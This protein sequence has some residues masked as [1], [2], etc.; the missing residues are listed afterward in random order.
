[1]T[2]K[3]SFVFLIL[4]KS[5]LES[6]DSLCYFISFSL[7]FPFSFCYNLFLS[8][9]PSLCTC[10]HS[11]PTVSC[12][13]YNLSRVPFP[14][15]IQARRVFLQNNHISEIG[16]GLFSPLTSVLWLFSNHITFL[17]PD[18]FHRLE[19]LEE[20]DLSNNPYLPP[21]QTNTFEGL[22][23]L[24]SLHLY[25]CHI[26]WLPA[27]LFKGLYSLRYLY[28]QHNH[29]TQLQDG[30]F[31]DLSNLSQLFLHGNLLQSLSTE[32][33]LGL[34]N[35]DRLLL[36][37]NQLV[38]V[39]TRAFWG[40]NSLTVLFLFNNSLSSLPGDSLQPLT[41]LQFLRLNGNPW[42]C[43][44][45]CHSLWGWFH[46]NP[47]IS[48]SPVLCA[49]P[50]SLQGRDMRSLDEKDMHFCSSHNPSFTRNLSGIAF[51]PKSS[52]FNRGN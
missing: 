5:L 43:D 37:S 12:Q 28:L 26:K 18:T 30:L 51:S 8:P 9:C 40:L 7:L 50:P 3:I 15:P 14:L 13:S 17:Q 33:F 6:S 42:H 4:L 47:G 32:L 16:P 20:L 48:S 44:C 46:S 52:S 38:S 27:G 11:P 19:N 36:H 49:S 34:C 22:K 45:S 24:R 21:L 29:L 1:M 35:L 2:T 31:Q 25:H 23:S 39:S 10:Y 41:S